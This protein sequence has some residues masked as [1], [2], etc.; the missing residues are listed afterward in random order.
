MHKCTTLE[1]AM[2]R[3]GKA[4]CRYLRSRKRIS[5]KLRT[6]LRESGDAALFHR[7]DVEAWVG[8]WMLQPLPEL[9]GRSPVQVLQHPTGWTVVERVLGRMRGGVCA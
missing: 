5:A 3:S 6:L 8:E 2:P 7:F 1:L 9:N 4:L